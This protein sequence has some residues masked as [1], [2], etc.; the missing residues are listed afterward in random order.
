MSAQMAV[1]LLLNHCW[2]N[3]LSTEYCMIVGSLRDPVLSRARKDAKINAP[4]VSLAP[5]LCDFQ[6]ALKTNDTAILES[7]MED[8]R[9]RLNKADNSMV[10][11]AYFEIDRGLN[12]SQQEASLKRMPNGNEQTIFKFLLTVSIYILTNAKRIS[13]DELDELEKLI[14]YFNQ[15]YK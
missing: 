10:D 7:V 12:G 11:A 3:G 4:V 1:A 5:W 14:K 13:K 6:R 2:G 9:H 15:R 8:I